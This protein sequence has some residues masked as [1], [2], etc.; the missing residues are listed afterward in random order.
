MKK[1]WLY[2]LALLCCSAFAKPPEQKDLTAYLFVYFTGNKV[3]EE[4][5]HF[6]VSADGYHYYALNHNQPVLDS[7]RIS[8]SGGVRDPHILRS[9]D[10]Q[11]F[12]MV[13]TDMT[14]SKGWDSNRAMV[15]LK[16]TDLVHWQ[17][18]VVNIQ[19]RFS[20]NSTLKR[21]WAPETI[22]DAKA[23]KYLIYFSMKHGNSPDKLYYSYANPSFTD[24]A[25]TPKPL[26][27]PASGKAAIDAD[28]IEKD[29]LYHLFYKTEGHGDGI[30]EA[31]SH[32]LT[33]NQWQEQNDYKQQTQD[34]VEGAG[35][36]KLS[37]TDS[38][39]LM[40]DVYKKGRYQFTQSQDLRHFTA[41]DNDISM[42]FHPRHGT[43]M[44]ITRQ[45]L[46]R[47]FRAFGKPSHYPPLNHNPVIA[48]YYAD[49]DALYSHLTHRYYIYPTS[50]GFTGWS[51]D[52]FK[53]FS[54][55]NLSDWRAEGSILNLKTEVSWANSHAWAPTMA[56]KKI[57]GHYRYFFYFTADGNIG[58]ASSAS[59]TGPFVDSGKPLISTLPKG[60]SGGQ[61][62]DPAVFT[63]PKTGKS[64]LYWG[65]GYMAVA[66]LSDDMLSLKP[67]TTRTITPDSDFR[68]GSKVFYRQGIYYFLWSQDDTR[69]PNYQV[70][71][72]TSDNPYGPIRVPKHNLVIA[73]DP[74]KGIYGTGHNGV[75]KVAGRD[76]WYLLYHRFS[77]PNGITMGD[78]AGYHREVCIDKLHFGPDGHIVPVIPTLKGVQP[79][80]KAKLKNSG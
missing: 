42:D 18:R 70:R 60:V 71:Y 34:A 25:T 17:S 41:V 80:P 72:G 37:N 14:A 43:V 32:S 19:Q 46:Q 15:L 53:A 76:E 73:K 5:I 31:T 74:A 48:G 62:I 26:F 33:A 6:A 50:D 11:H 24:L 12:Y 67:G 8:S 63:D 61:Q 2:L 16:S 7:K 20:G 75:I 29:S 57:H 47:L 44:A 21:V 30:K 52:D 1:T 10:G 66:E 27:T 78:A 9:Q 13:A 59:P 77:I 49:P 38:Y 35:V 65:N 58:V 28:I 54:S 36:F 55:A 64:Y 39:I 68:E 69:S 45:E 3:S 22:F 56:E 79:L 4:A 40:Y 23:G 51:G